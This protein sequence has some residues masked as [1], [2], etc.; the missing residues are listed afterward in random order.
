MIKLLHPQVMSQLSGWETIRQALDP[1]ACWYW[2]C[3]S[4]NVLNWWY[5]P[6]RIPGVQSEVDKLVSQVTLNGI[7]AINICQPG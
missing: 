2:D 3:V 5:L 4:W 6:Y 7:K 1:W